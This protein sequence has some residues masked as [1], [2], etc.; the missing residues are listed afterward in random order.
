M[1]N[2]EWAQQPNATLGFFC[3]EAVRWGGRVNYF[4]ES[5]PTGTEEGTLASLDVQDR[6]LEVFKILTRDNILVLHHELVEVF[7][8]NNSF[9]TPGPGQKASKVVLESRQCQAGV[10]G[11]THECPYFT[12][13]HV[14][15]LMKGGL[16]LW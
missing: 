11:L 3:V 7:M 14:Y 12:R 13:H 1:A 15:N 6:G 8:G 4:L 2:G 9:V 10:A 5:H 16:W